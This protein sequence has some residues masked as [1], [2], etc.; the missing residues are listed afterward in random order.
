MA[1]LPRTAREHSISK[2]RVAANSDRKV[3]LRHENNTWGGFSNLAIKNIRGMTAV[4][5]HSIRTTH[6]SRLCDG[7]TTPL[8]DVYRLH[9]QALAFDDRTFGNTNLLH[10]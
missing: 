3:I 10:S 6:A 9:K 4:S 1:G 8:G 7:A 2:P 5:Q